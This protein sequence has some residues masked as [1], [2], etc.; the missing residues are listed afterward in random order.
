MQ[1]IGLC[2]FSFPAL[3]SFQI[4]HETIDKRRHH[5]YNPNRLEERFRLFE[6]STLPCFR[7]QTD[8]DFELLV[9]T[10][11]CLPK[12]ARE[13]LNDLTADV[14][15][16]R[17]VSKPADSGLKTRQ[18]MRDVLNEARADPDQPCIQ[19]RHDDDDAVS[20]D[21]VERLRIAIHEGRGLVE[22]HSTVAV[23]F[24]HGFLARCD[25]D[26]IQAARVFINQLGVGLGMYVAGGCDKAIISYTHNKIGRSMP[27]ISY[28]DAPMWVRTLH[29]FNDSPHARKNKVDLQPLTPEMEGEFIARY[30]I[31]Q[32]V[33]RKVHGAA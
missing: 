8:E 28:G 9:V 13:R 7:E 25:A 1:V 2:R 17:I 19:F 15:Q 5:L 22:S 4:E 11:D 26:G 6:S 18:V 31:D 12:Q 27:V 21:L 23:D 10:G 32:E 30:A 24:C 14:K 29:E 33:V 3:G 20:V 16:V